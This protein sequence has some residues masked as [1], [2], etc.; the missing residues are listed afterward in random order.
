VKDSRAG[1][2]LLGALSAYWL[3]LLPGVWYIGSQVSDR[4]VMTI[5][6]SQREYY[7]TAIPSRIANA[8]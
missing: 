5:G 4:E 7:S 3:V 8:V 6:S 1:F 2:K